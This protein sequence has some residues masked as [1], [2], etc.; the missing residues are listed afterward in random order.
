[1][2]G[3]SLPDTDHVLRY[4]QPRC[5]EHV[6]GT[7]QIQGAAFYSRPRDD[8]MTSFNWMECHEGS[9]EEQVREI[10]QRARMQYKASGLLAQLNV[11]H[12]MSTLRD[13]F[14]ED[15]LSQFVHDPLDADDQ[16]PLADIS[17]SLMMHMPADGEPLAEAIG[18]VLADC[19]ITHY[20]TRD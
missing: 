4:V 2:K 8:N 20:S 3:D 1:M 13:A 18:D 19:I 12:V 16:F 11:G 9:W 10:R 14:Q 6:D 5:I 7:P 15:C 17:H